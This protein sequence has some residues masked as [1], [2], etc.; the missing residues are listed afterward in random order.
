MSKERLEGIREDVRTNARKEHE[1]ITEILFDD[2]LW[3]I[4]QAERVQ[5]LENLVKCER[6]IAGR[7][8]KRVDR[9][10]R[11]NKRMHEALV[12]V[13]DYLQDGRSA[14]ANRLYNEIYKLLE[15]SE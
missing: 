9:M 1:I 8:Q 11:Q 14:K 13:M 6:N 2:A 15:E 12:S 10:E 7:A 3:L 5:E 4:E